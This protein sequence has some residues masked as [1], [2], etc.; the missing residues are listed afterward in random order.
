MV[1]PDEFVRSTSP[2]LPTLTI[3][4]LP[5]VWLGLKFTFD[6]I[7]RVTPCGNTVTYPPACVPASTVTF[8]ATAPTPDAG[9]PP[10]PSTVRETVAPPAIGPVVPPVPTLVSMTRAGVNATMPPPTATG[11]GAVAGRIAP[12]RIGGNASALTGASN[13]MTTKAPNERA[14]NTRLPRMRTSHPWNAT[15]SRRT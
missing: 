7:G 9:T 4:R 6:V 11:A 5:I 10:A 1:P 2:P 15:S 14:R 12:A 13:A 8:N 3:T